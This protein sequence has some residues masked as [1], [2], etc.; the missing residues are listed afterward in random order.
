M[1]G[2]RKEK[3]CDQGDRA[4]TRARTD[5]ARPKKKGTQHKILTVHVHVCAH[6]CACAGCLV[7][8]A[9]KPSGAVRSHAG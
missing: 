1:L 9:S 2:P 6:M 7:D 5:A 3:R 8:V 4:L